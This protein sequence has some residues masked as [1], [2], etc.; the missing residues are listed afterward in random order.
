[1]DRRVVLVPGATPSEAGSTVPPRSYSSTRR[2]DSAAE[3]I[4]DKVEDCNDDLADEG[5]W[6][7]QALQ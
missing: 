2:T 7:E 6:N 5:K 1:M 3:D 4:D